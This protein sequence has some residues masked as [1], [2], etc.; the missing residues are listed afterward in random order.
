[1]IRITLNRES[2][3]FFIRMNGFGDLIKNGTC[4]VGP[5]LPTTLIRGKMEGWVRIRVAGQTDWKRVWMVVSAGREGVGID[6]AT[7]GAPS[8]SVP[9]KKRMSNLFSR[10]QSPPRPTGPEKPTIT[11]YG[12]PKPKEKKK[13]WLSLRDITQAFAVYPERPEL[14]TRSTLIKLEGLLGDEEMAQSMKSREGWILFMPEMEGTT[15]NHAM[16]ML[17]WVIGGF[18]LWLFLIFERI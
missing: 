15:G 1:M 9:K 3:F 2:L 5:D 12:G 10:D 4:N 6:N 17:K 18:D 8:S 13:P 7:S 14:I 16:E 11:M